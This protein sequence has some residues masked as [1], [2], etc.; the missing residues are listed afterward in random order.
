M[1][2]AKSRFKT[3]EQYAALN[4]SELPEGNYELVEG[5]IVEMGAESP[6]NVVIASFLFAMLLQFCPYYLLHRG[7]EIAVSGKLV[8]SRYPDLMVLTEAGRAALLGQKRSLI[9]PEMPAPALVIEIVS[10]GA[11]SSSNYQRDYADK[12]EEYAKRGIPE[13]WRIDPERSVVSV[14]VLEGK[15]YTEKVFRGSDR[16]QSAQFNQLNL[17][18]QQILSAGENTP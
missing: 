17:T 5:E 7:T 16:I 15:A 12:P 8:T 11:P 18:A 2:Q 14:L 1:T 13:F 10:P 6:E 9:T 4:P 3:L